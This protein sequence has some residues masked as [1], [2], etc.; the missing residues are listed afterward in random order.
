MPLYD[1]RFQDRSSKAKEIKFFWDVLIFHYP[2][3]ITICIDTL[4]L[5]IRSCNCKSKAQVIFQHGQKPHLQTTIVNT[6]QQ[7]L[8]FLFCIIYEYS[9][10][11]SQFIYDSILYLDSKIQSLRYDCFSV[12]SEK[13]RRRNTSLSDFTVNHHQISF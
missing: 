6:V 5:K 2:K 7:F 4:A 1:R 10:S 9:V 3:H 8:K 13:Q 12:Q 11:V